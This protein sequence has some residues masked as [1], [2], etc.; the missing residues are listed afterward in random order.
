MSWRTSAKSSLLATHKALIRIV[1]ATDLLHADLISNRPIL[2]TPET[3][4][5]GDPMR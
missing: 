1:E 4:Q 5:A 2:D 3:A